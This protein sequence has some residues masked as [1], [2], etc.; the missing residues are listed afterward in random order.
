MKG[1]FIYNIR[2]L[3]Y[4]SRAELE[5]LLN[6]LGADGWEAEQFMFNCKD[7]AVAGKH[8]SWWVLKM[9]L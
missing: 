7:K 3:E 9:A 8:G 2:F 4:E 6:S 1:H 5:Q